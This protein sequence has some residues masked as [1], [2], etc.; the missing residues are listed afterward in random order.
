M[1]HSLE[2]ARQAEAAAGGDRVK[3]FLWL[4]QNPE[5]DQAV[6]SG[7]DCVDECKQVKCA[8]GGVEAAIREASQRGDRQ[9]IAR[10]MRL[11]A[12][13]RQV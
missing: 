12:T 13:G 8:S 3:A 2:R 1:G 10:L 7:V 11:R 6:G 4:K 5:M 9:E